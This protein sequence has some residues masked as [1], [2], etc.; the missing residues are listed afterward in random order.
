MA[1]GK[2]ENHRKMIKKN[3]GMKMVE[4]KEMLESGKEGDGKEGERLKLSRGKY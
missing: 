3:K 2:G 4:D 1:R